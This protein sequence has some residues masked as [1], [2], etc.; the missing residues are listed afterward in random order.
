MLELNS[1]S[2]SYH[3]APVVQA[4]SMRVE[5]GETAKDKLGSMVWI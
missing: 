2:A 1:V 5:T 3:L 4:L